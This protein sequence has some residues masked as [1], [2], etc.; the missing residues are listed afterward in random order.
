MKQQKSLYAGGATC[1]QNLVL[2]FEYCFTY[3]L[4]F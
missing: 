4:F 3:S 2:C 1:T